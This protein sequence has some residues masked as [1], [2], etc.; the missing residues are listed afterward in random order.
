MVDVISQPQ[1]TQES[2]LLDGLLDLLLTFIEVGSV[3]SLADAR[4]YVHSSLEKWMDISTAMIASDFEGRLA[5]NLLLFNTGRSLPDGDKLASLLRKVK[6]KADAEFP[7]MVLARE[8]KGSKQVLTIR[9]PVPDKDGDLQNLSLLINFA[10]TLLGIKDDCLKVV[11]DETLGKAV[12]LPASQAKLLDSIK[13]SATLPEGDFLGEKLTFSSGFKGNLVEIL[14]AIRVLNAKLGMVRARPTPPKGN[15][16]VPVTLQ[17]LKANYNLKAGLDKTSSAYGL[18]FVKATLALLCRSTNMHFPGGW[19]NSARKSNG[20]TTTEGL[21]HSLGYTFVVPPDIKIRS[22]LMTRTTIDPK[23]NKKLSPR[24][25][26]EDSVYTELRTALA[27]SLPKIDPKSSTSIET[28]MKT[29]VL[30]IKN[31]STISAFKENKRLKCVDALNTAYAIQQACKDPKSKAKPE[32]FESARNHLLHMSYMIDLRDA[33][34]QSYTRI[35]D[36]PSNAKDHLVKV[37]KAKNLMTK[38]RSAEDEGVAEVPSKKV[39]QVSTASEDVAM[40]E[41]SQL[42]ESPCLECEDTLQKQWTHFHV[43]RVVGT[44]STGR[45]LVEAE[46]QSML[47]T[48]PTFSGS[49]SVYWRDTQTPAYR[50]DARELGAVFDGIRK[51]VLSKVPK[52]LGVKGKTPARK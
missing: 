35:S 12:T 43:K 2:V 19:I 28:Q 27:L 45:V 44:S 51:D 8:P 40:T 25:D 41:D 30:S 15:R 14:C 3:K 42:V 5:M 20:V 17:N 1:G 52:G 47:E 4:L 18:K 16:V 11:K 49:S 9:I 7:I 38:K 21:L 36:I 37:F 48:S 39:P 13:L 32:H 26:T 22:V 46:T 6:V 10:T 24:G 31:Q 29:D 50:N 34:S 33:G 23:G